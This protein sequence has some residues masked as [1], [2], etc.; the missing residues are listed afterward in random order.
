MDVYFKI[1]KTIQKYAEMGA[2]VTY[3]IS[4]NLSYIQVKRIK[5]K[6]KNEHYTSNKSL[7]K[8]SLDFTYSLPKKFVNKVSS[9]TVI[10][11]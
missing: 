3:I 8:S 10:F 11:K 4:P 9:E 1:I 5:K 2:S 7:F 6:R